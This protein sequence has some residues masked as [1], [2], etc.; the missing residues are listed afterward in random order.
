[1]NTFGKN[2]NAMRVRFNDSFYR[3]DVSSASGKK[4]SKQELDAMKA[5]LQDT[6]IDLLMLDKDALIQ[7]NQAL[8]AKVYEL[9]A[10]CDK[11]SELEQRFEGIE[12]KIEELNQSV[13]NYQAGAWACAIVAVFLCVVCFVLGY[14]NKRL[15]EAQKM[16]VVK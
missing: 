10:Q 4:V 3:L 15:K 9:E 8:E 12:E 7:E 16:E 5:R 11:C 1:M 6:S 13:F 2:N 14:E